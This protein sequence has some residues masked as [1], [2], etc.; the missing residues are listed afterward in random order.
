MSWHVVSML[1]QIM[2]RPVASGATLDVPDRDLVQ[3]VLDGDTEGFEILVLRYQ[4]TIHTLLYR[5]LRDREAAREATQEA[6]LRAFRKLALYD[7][8]HSFKSWLLTLSVNVARSI[9]RRSVPDPVDMGPGSPVGHNTDHLLSGSTPA[10]ESEA[11]RRDTGRVLERVVAELPEKYRL[12]IL[13]RHGEG[14]LYKEVAETLGVPLGTVKFRLHH[15]YGL[16]RT[17]LGK[18]GLLPG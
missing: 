18:E 7:S 3:N 11:V 5:V 14:M 13:L 10:P 4:D 6:F 17:S 1:G 16:L 15:A 9:R 8:K 2:T 12:A